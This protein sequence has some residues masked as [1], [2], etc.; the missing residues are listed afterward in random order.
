MPAMK[1]E[2]E[3]YYPLLDLFRFFAAIGI[4][5]L[6]IAS[7]PW[8]ERSKTLGRFAVPFF[9]CTATYLAFDI[10]RR[11]PETSIVRYFV[12]RFSRIYPLFLAWS[13]IY[14]AARNASSV[15]LEHKG[16]LKSDVREFFF[17]GIAIQLWFL[18]FIIVVTS[19]AFAVAK[20]ASIAP[21][22]R[23][24]MIVLS[25]VIGV[26]VAVLPVPDRIQAAG[27]SP[28][29][30]YGAL[31]ACMWGVTLGLLAQYGITSSARL[32]GRFVAG[33][34]FLNAA[35]TVAGVIGFLAW[36]ILSLI[37]GRSLFWENIA[38]LSLLLIAS[39]QV[40]FGSVPMIAFLGSIS[41]GIYLSHALFVEGLQHVLPKF[42]VLPGGLSSLM[43]L[44]LS[45]LGSCALVVVLRRW[46]R[47]ARWLVK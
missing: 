23:W 19:L 33:T 6:H 39:N 47:W 28:S 41:F 46:G 11:R 43:I 18:P 22:T 3:K 29:L 2:Q 12:Q 7:A 31:P 16:Y 14:W 25:A 21:V 26:L 4:I 1:L 9:A 24:P 10:L 42:G 32:K 27:Y 30:G 34:P 36:L 17:D 40:A 13:L 5:W 15:L 37:Y 8:L 45:L 20:L 44:P 35:N 38:G